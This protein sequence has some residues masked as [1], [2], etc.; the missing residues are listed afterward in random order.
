MPW[1][2]EIKLENGSFSLNSILGKYDIGISLDSLSNKKFLEE[3]KLWCNI[4]YKSLTDYCD[5]MEQYHGDSLY[6][7]CENIKRRFD[8]ETIESA[9]R[10]KYINEQ[11]KE[12]FN[13]ALFSYNPYARPAKNNKSSNPQNGYVYVIKSENGLYKIG[14]AKNLTNRILHLGIKIPMKIELCCSCEYEDYDKA[15]SYFHQL[16]SI[17]RE[18]GEWFR[19]SDEDI[20]VVKNAMSNR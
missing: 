9:L 16:F 17:K 12:I 14:K 10:S 8:R 7:K 5:I 1:M 20:L 4:H 15:E 6:E 2:Q 11:E 19:L 18:N 3:L 13:N